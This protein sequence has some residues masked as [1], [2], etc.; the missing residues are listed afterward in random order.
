[1][2]KIKEIASIC[3][4]DKKLNVIYDKMEDSLS[5]Y[6]KTDEEMKNYIDSNTDKV[7]S[8]FVAKSTNGIYVLNIASTE[9]FGHFDSWK[10]MN[11]LLDMQLSIFMPIIQKFILYAH[12]DNL[13]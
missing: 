4:G 1:M 3:I 12:T 5:K 10:G 2:S 13:D 8:H 7:Y 9:N 6:F 11:T